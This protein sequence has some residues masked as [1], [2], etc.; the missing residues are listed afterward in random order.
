[1]GGQVASNFQGRGGAESGRAS[2]CGLRFRDDLPP[3]TRC[4]DRD[5]AQHVFRGEG[6]ARR[7]E[8]PATGGRIPPQSTDDAKTGLNRDSFGT[9][10][11]PGR[12]AASPRQQ[13]PDTMRPRK[14]FHSDQPGYLDRAHKTNVRSSLRLQSTLKQLGGSQAKQGFTASWMVLT[15]GCESITRQIGYSPDPG[16]PERAGHHDHRSEEHTSEL[17]SPM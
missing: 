7:Q 16:A 17:Q 14:L 13:P 15:H 10:A 4:Q 8:G 12:P 6:G 2:G 1:M 11:P 3:G 9:V 5:R